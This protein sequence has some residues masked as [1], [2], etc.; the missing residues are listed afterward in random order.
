[1]PILSKA[2]RTVSIDNEVGKSSYQGYRFPGFEIP[3]VVR[4]K[5]CLCHFSQSLVDVSVACR[6]LRKARR[7]LHVLG[8]R[9]VRAGLAQP[10]VDQ[11]HSNIFF[12]GQKWAHR[13]SPLVNS[14]TNTTNAISEAL[15]ESTCWSLCGRQ[16]HHGTRRNDVLQAMPGM[17]G[18]GLAEPGPQPPGRASR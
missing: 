4:G 18:H 2:V 13:E 17:D 3:E 5:S 1:M 12:G 9:S 15:K 16:D 10:R 7:D 6:E 8:V 11:V 14:L